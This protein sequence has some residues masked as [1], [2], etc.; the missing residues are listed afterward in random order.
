MS[1]GRLG[2]H[3]PYGEY[4]RLGRLVAGTQRGCLWVGRRP[5]LL[6][7]AVAGAVRLGYVLTYHPGISYELL[8][9]LDETDYDALAVNLL[10]FGRFAVFTEG[11]LTQ[12]TR[13][14]GYPVFLALLYGALGHHLLVARLANAALGVLAVWLSYGL[15]RRLT[16]G[17]RWSQSVALV[18]AGVHAL[19][20]LPVLSESRI[21]GE[22]L[23]IVLVLGLALALEGLGRGVG[24]KR[25]FWA[26]ILGVG[27]IHVRPVFLVLVPIVA[28][29]AY[30]RLRDGVGRRTSALW[31]ATLAGV[32]VAGCVPWFVRSQLVLGRVVPISSVSGWHLLAGSASLDRLPAD[33][34]RQ[35]AYGY[36]GKREGELFWQSAGEALATM[37]RQPTRCLSAGLVRLWRSWGF[38]DWYGRFWRPRA[39]VVPLPFGSASGRSYESHDRPAGWWL[40]LV[41]FEGLV[42][43]AAMLAVWSVVSGRWR[44]APWDVWWGRCRPHVLL[45]AGYVGVHVLAVPFVQYRLFVEPLLVACCLPAAAWVLCPSTGSGRPESQTSE[46]GREPSDRTGRRIEEVGDLPHRRG[47]MATCVVGVLLLGGGWWLA[48]RWQW[49]GEGVPAV[50]EAEALTYFSRSRPQA[51]GLRQGE[52]PLTFEEVRTYQYGHLGAVDGLVGR[53]VLWAGEFGYCGPGFRYAPGAAGFLALVREPGWSVVRLVVGRDASRGRLGLRP[54]RFGAGDVRVYVRREATGSEPPL[55]ASLRER[56]GAVLGRIR[57]TDLFGGVIVEAEDVLLR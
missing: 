43:V 26:G 48:Y 19:S 30:L 6:V 32:M 53:W 50:S 47:R 17:A 5:L 37:T 33:A 55:P 20:G 31:S 15:V 42:Y 16:A 29:A 18:A 45:V 36:P 54:L 25:V 8:P 27:L 2:S 57:G 1:G 4:G 3:S 10:R 14:P 34:A 39:Y 38:P 28:S 44:R 41:D 35:Y 52:E 24:W 9:F 11:H 12:G 56:P 46:T 23:G 13:P 7:L 21:T 49:R 22:E 51:F 40:P